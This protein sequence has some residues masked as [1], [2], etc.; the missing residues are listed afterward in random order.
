MRLRRA[1]SIAALCVLTSA[2]TAYAECAR[3]LWTEY[4]RIGPTYS[5]EWQVSF[6]VPTWDECLSAAKQRA[7]NLTLLAKDP[8]RAPGVKP[9]SVE[10]TELGG[11]KEGTR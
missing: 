2:A 7:I 11:A 1:S 3:V 5:R 8:V 6:A 10:I 4:T 9:G